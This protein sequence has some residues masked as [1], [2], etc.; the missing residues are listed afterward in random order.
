MSELD[1]NA[2]PRFT[3]VKRA[4]MRAGRTALAGVSA[5][6]VVVGFGGCGDEFASCEASRNCAASGGSGAGG[7]GNDGGSSDGGSPN[8]PGA[9]AGGLSGDGGVTSTGG[10][11]GGAGAPSAEAGAAGAGGDGSVNGVCDAG[12]SPRQARCLVADEFAVFVAPNGSDSGAGSKAQ[13]FK[14]ITRALKANTNKNIIVCNAAF[15]ESIKTEVGGRLYGGFGCPGTNAPWVYQPG[16]Y[17]TVAPLAAATA[18][19]VHAAGTASIV[20]DFDFQSEAATT[21][22]GSS[23]AVML[24]QAARV[25]F[26]RVKFNAGAG[27]DGAAGVSGAKGADGL[28]S[29]AAQNGADGSCATP[30]AGKGQGLMACN[31][32]GGMGG[33][34]FKGPGA[35]GNPGSPPG[36]LNGGVPVEIAGVLGMNGAGG[37]FGAAGKPGAAAAVD[38]TFAET[39]YVP[40]VDGGPGLDGETAEAG[41][42]GASSD[43][44]ANC[45][46][47]GGGAGGLGGCGGK[48]GTGGA[49]GGASIAL[50]VWETPVTLEG[51]K[52]TS[53]KG[54]TGGK[55]GDGGPG[56][57]GA[58]GA[59]GGAGISDFGIIKGGNGGLGGDGGS[60]GPGAGGNG[61]PSIVIVYWGT[62][63]TL[64]ANTA[65]QVGDAGAGGL[66]G[67]AGSSTAAAGF[68]GF[69]AT[70]FLTKQL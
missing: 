7:K 63:P 6:A 44:T 68:P 21:P 55:G 65:L 66:A 11:P 38:G 43:G 2:T 36:A 56:G 41:G 13:P 27:A 61:G 4:S 35:P 42:G 14:T 49:A 5:L 22:G 25:T 32:I 50:F 59:F 40:P 46:G 10:T 20:E 57:K 60:G 62:A 31:S 67:T 9:G 58:A 30:T 28:A 52:L 34:G 64:D 29:T 15:R 53:S 18:L 23:V 39:G 48:L 69:N 1:S 45:Y 12:L 8:E 3:V 47:A 16:T 17:T 24:Q 19:T 54:G 70:L 26:R 33:P 51:C 37:L